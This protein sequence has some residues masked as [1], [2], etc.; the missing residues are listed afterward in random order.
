M[1]KTILTVAL[2]SLIGVVSAQ[3]PA[4]GAMGFTAGLPGG[5]TGTVGGGPNNI[6]SLQFKYYVSDG[7]AARIGLNLSVPGG[8]GTEV[9]DSLAGAGGNKYIQ[10]KVTS[11][12][13]Q[14]ALTLGAQK[15]IGGT[16]KL[17]VYAGGDLVLGGAMSNEID[18][19]KDYVVA[20]GGRVKGDYDQ[21]VVTN[22]SSWNFG[23]NGILGFQYFLVEKLAVG[24]EFG[25]GYR[26]GGSSGTAQTVATGL[27][28]ATTV[29]K[30]TPSNDGKSSTTHGISTTGG[31]ITVSF[32][33]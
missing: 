8:N 25:Y 28:G 24:A 22:P 7:L 33:F 29:T 23:L 31:T 2:A 3:K 32:F 9:S 11:G 4:A 6:G 5:I 12:G 21:T 17:D 16:D 27:S 26:V 19:K 18:T 20:G 30:T 14:W 13:T 10:T 1:K 15:T